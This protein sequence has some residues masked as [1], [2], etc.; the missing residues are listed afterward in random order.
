MNVKQYLLLEGRISITSIW[1][2]NAQKD[3]VT[4]MKGAI[5]DIR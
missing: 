2:Q 4:G 5:L 1:K 3:I